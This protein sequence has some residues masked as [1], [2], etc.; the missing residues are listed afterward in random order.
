Y[1]KET[2]KKHMMRIQLTSTSKWTMFVLETRGDLEAV[3]EGINKGLKKIGRSSPKNTPQPGGGGGKRKKEAPSSGKGSGPD[4]LGVGP[5]PASKTTFSGPPPPAGPPHGQ[6][7]KKKRKKGGRAT[8]IIESHEIASTRASL[9]ANDEELRAHYN[10]LVG[11]G[12]VD[13]AR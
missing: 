2:D 5:T 13:E 10:E 11:T 12:V 8:S 6:G 3:K 9:L 7:G 4:D 1:S